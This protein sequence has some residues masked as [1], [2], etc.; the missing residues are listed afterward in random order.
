MVDILCYSSAVPSTQ[1]ILQQLLK[2]TPQRTEMAPKDCRGIYG[3]VDHFGNLRYI[4]STSS[5]DET[6]HK[7]I[8]HRHRTGS[9]TASHYF[10]RMYNTGRMWRLRNDPET[11][12]DGDIAKKLRNAFIAEY[13]RAVWVALPDDVDITKLENDVIALAPKGA[14]AWNRR[15]MDAYEEPECLVDVIIDRLGFGNAERAAL[16]RQKARFLEGVVASAESLPATKPSPLAFPK[17]P[18]RFAALDVETANHDR[19]SICQIGVACVRLDNSIETWVTYVDP[20]TDH[21]FFSGLHGITSTMV[22]EAPRFD[23]VLPELKKAL[24]RLEVYQ[25]SG[26]DRSAI[27]A[28]CA[29]I[30]QPEPDWDWQNSVTVARLAWPELKGNGGHGLASLKTHLGLKFEH[31]DAGE[32]ARAAAQVVLLA[33][34]SG[35]AAPKTPIVDDQELQPI[36]ELQTPASPGLAVEKQTS[37]RPK[38]NE[39]ISSSRLLGFSELT[40]GNIKNNHFYLREVWA[41]FPEDCIGGSNAASAALK[42]V[43]V[44]WEGAPAVITDLD[45]KKKLFRKRGWVS[46][47]FERNDARAGDKVKISVIG[48]Y[49]YEVSIV[50]HNKI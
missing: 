12:T 40:Q 22:A 38:D 46:D 21:W 8:H 49:E 27:R 3:L 31:H 1:E 19:G 47:F 7:R 34:R 48:P 20:Q 35:E 32:D 18:F 28:A 41:A 23:E 37:D 13:C 36:N 26:F 9:E 25:H 5:A 30:G 29:A 4:G 45:G 16:K 33:E 44:K 39:S 11:K 24:G 6:F 50:R 2:A 15:G 17:G 10:S 42:P 43:T 14:I